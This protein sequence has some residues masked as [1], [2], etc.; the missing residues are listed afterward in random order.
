QDMLAVCEVCDLYVNP[1]RAGGGSSVAEAMFKGLPA[2]TLAHGDVA[3]G[4]G[5][6]FCVES[7]EAMR[8]QIARYAADR[9][10]YAEMS[11]KAKSRAAEIMD[12]DSALAEI[13]RA[14]VASPLFR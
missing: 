12:T 13:V 10:F 5:P 2:V 6:D 7:Y 11:Q 14:V 4:A 8:A 3:V 1:L 9:G